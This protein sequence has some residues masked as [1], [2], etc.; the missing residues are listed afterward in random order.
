MQNTTNSVLTKY[1]LPKHLQMKKYSHPKLIYTRWA[2]SRDEFATLL[3]E[4]A[5]VVNNTPLWEVSS[6]PDDPCPISPAMLLT[7]HENPNPAP[8][9]NFTE[10]DI[11]AYGPRRWRRI[12]YLADQFWSRWKTEYFSNLQHRR[13][14]KQVKSY[15][16]GDIVLVKDKNLKRNMWLMGKISG[17]K[18]SKDGLIRTVYINVINKDGKNKIKT[19]ERSVH[20]IVTLLSHSSRKITSAD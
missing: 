2:L 9:D 8:W 13:K 18:P 17:L 20:N 19:I 6:S 3:Q 1:K 5:S 15:S 16:T 4:A 12:Q 10:N 11:H 14:W 7:L